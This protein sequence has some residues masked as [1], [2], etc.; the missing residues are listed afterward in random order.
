MAI[1]TN[2]ASVALILM[3]G[4]ALGQEADPLRTN[5]LTGQPRPMFDP[6]SWEESKLVLDACIDR[7]LAETPAPELVATCHA[8][9]LASCAAIMAL[10]PLARDECALGA[11]LA[12]GEVRHE[13]GTRV[14]D[15][16]MVQDR[17]AAEAFWAEDDAWRV[18]GG[19][20]CVTPDPEAYDA[21]ALAR[22]QERATLYLGRAASVLGLPAR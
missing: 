5:P 19:N 1:S 18:E 9:A 11:R 8:E 22:E 7:G 3:A 13:V 17:A 15:L 12:W 6:T 4:A 20:A 14:G 10:Y 16:L 21:C 2:A